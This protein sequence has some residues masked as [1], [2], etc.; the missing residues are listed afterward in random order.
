MK[1]H[2]SHIGTARTRR[3]NGDAF[4]L[5][6]LLVV[7]TIIGILIALLLPA[8]QA[9]REAARRAQCVNNLKQLGL[10]LHNYH[11]VF[12]CFPAAES[13]SM[14]TQC[15]NDCR[16]T[17]LYI[18]LLPYIE[19]ASLDENAEYIHNLE[20]GWAWWMRLNPVTGE[21]Q[22]G[23]N[24]SYW[25]PYALI[26]LP[27]YQCPSDPRLDYIPPV[28]DYFGCTGGKDEPG[29]QPYDTHWGDLYTNGLFTMTQWRR[30]ADVADGTSS[31]FAFG[32]SIHN[33]R[34]TTA[35]D[36]TKGDC[37]DNPQGGHVPWFFGSSCQPDGNN[38]TICGT[39]F[40]HISRCCR[41]TE[42]PINS[43]I[44]PILQTNE[45]EAPFGSYHGGGAHFAFVDGH[46]TFI[47]DTIYKHVYDALGT[48]AGQE[49]ISGSDY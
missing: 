34:Y 17:P 23:G 32:E 27:V 14:D 18:S 36:G 6:E 41:S 9:A 43:E 33:S 37:Y 12:N 45:N 5:V 21:I 28:R 25:N 1:T 46:V 31:S 47:N 42:H 20:R 4:T 30:M 26:P 2:S 13:I 19:Q 49:I 11:S 3:L 16:G 35:P 44:T 38:P 8:V 15:G 39:Y 22:A 10:A 7:I 29:K 40:E 24:T 48:I